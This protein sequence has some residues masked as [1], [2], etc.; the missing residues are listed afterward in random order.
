MGILD[1]LFRVSKGKLNEGVDKLEDATLR[2][3]P[4]AEHSGHGG[5][6]FTG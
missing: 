2:V 4:A 1:R 5:T 6:S 3:D